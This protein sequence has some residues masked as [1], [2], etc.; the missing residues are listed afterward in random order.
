MTAATA[1][2]VTVNVTQEHLDNGKA[3]DC[4]ECPVALAVFAALPDAQIVNVRYWSHGGDDAREPGV[5][6]TVDFSPELTRRYRLPYEA[7]GNIG[8]IDSGIPVAPF[9]FEMEELT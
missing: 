5:H 6:V 7:A 3:G 9:T 4:A 8:R 1:E 2:R